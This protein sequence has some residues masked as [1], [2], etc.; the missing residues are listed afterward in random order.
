MN[1]VRNVNRLNAKLILSWSVENLLGAIL[2]FKMS[3]KF[4]EFKKGIV[5]LEKSSTGD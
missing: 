1:C 4:L 5:F 2:L 3:G